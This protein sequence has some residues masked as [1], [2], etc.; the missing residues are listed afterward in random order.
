MADSEKELHTKMI[1]F[2]KRY[3]YVYSEVWSDDKTSRIDLIISHHSDKEKKYPIG[4]EIK[5]KAKKKGKDLAEW[6]KQSARYSEKTFKGFGKCLIITCPQISGNYLKEGVEMHQHEDE[7][8]C[9]PDHNAST[10]LGQFKI[11]EFQKYVGQFDK[12]Y[13][14]IVYK[15][16]VIWDMKDNIL[17]MHNYERLVK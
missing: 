9:R 15:G 14:R 3:F 11:G 5:K 1:T 10:F 12:K 8:G 7:S 4:I 13:M 17:R 6:L 2:L 16:S